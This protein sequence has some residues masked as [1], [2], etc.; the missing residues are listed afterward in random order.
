MARGTFNNVL[1]HQESRPGD[2][3][4]KEQ[5]G[6]EYDPAGSSDLALMDGIRRRRAIWAF[7]TTVNHR[8]RSGTTDAGDYAGLVQH[9]AS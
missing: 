3:E 7:E 2:G 4:A 1:F 5:E 6:N 9:P 8:H